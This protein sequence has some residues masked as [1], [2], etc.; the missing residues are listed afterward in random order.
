MPKGRYSGML[1]AGALVLLALVWGFWPRPV[2]VEAG[3]VERRHLQVTVEEEGRTRVKDRYVLYAPVAGYLR[4]IEL[5]VGDAAEAGE[6]LALL[7]PLR[8]AVLDPRA[9]AEA[10]ARVSGARSALARAESTV[11]H[12]QA[13]AELAAEEYRRREELLAGGLVSRSEFD[14]AR[15]RM[16]ALEA[17]SRAADSAAEVAR[18]DLE[19]A[20]ASLRYS[21]VSE[22]H[23]P[24]ETVPVRSPV[25]G[26]VLKLL[27]ESAGVVPAGH[28]LLEVGDPGRLEVEVEVLSRDAVRILPGGRVLFERWGGA[29]ILEGVVRIV[30][31]TGF[32]KISALGVEEQRVLVIADLASP[33][34]AWQRLGD[35]YRVEA[36]F[37]VWEREDALTV[38]ASA[39]FRRD[40][41]WAVFVVENGR[42]R[43]RAVRLGQ[44]SGLFSE[45]L[46]G[47]SRGEQVIVH[48][49]DSVDAGVRV[50]PFGR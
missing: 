17:L 23:A 19:A 38:P 30:E 8:P 7:D 44:G 36:R 22:E 1:I 10:E 6:P 33:P 20:L 14:Q 29:E 41:G 3:V 32:T 49:D 37:V 16:R 2:M 21:A 48:P 18:Y 39:L 31:P 15:S 9:R 12:A 34:E 5:E 25:T 40:D 13:E 4:R 24:A 47:L 11:R 27:Q 50:R 43:F 45:V 28:P 26:R 46:D 42:A 35:G